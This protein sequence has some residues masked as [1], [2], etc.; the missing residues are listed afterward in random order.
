MGDSFE[1]ILFDLLN[2]LDEEFESDKKAAKKIKDIERIYQSAANRH[3]S[4]INKG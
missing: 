4:I 1:N 3:F 2:A